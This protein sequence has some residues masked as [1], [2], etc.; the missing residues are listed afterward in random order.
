MNDVGKPCEG[1]PHARIDGGSWKRSHDHRAS[2]LPYSQVN[3]IRWIIEQVIAPLKTW[4]SLH[5]DYRRP[6]GT[7]PTTISAV[8]ALHF[9][10]YA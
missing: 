6:I 4:R 5:T 2:F 1:E 7:F 9:W 10:S 3:K 8:I